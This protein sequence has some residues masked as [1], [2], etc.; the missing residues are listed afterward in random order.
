MRLDSHIRYLDEVVKKVR[1]ST[2]QYTAI[3]L[4]VQY[5]DLPCG[6]YEVDKSH[7]TL[8]SR[9]ICG[10]IQYV[11]HSSGDAS[12]NEIHTSHIGHNAIVHSMT[13][14]THKTVEEIR[15]SIIELIELFFYLALFGETEGTASN[16]LAPDP[17]WL[18]VVMHTI[19]DACSPAHV[20]RKHMLGSEKS[21]VTRKLLEYANN[22][23]RILSMKDVMKRLKEELVFQLE[24]MDKMNPQEIYHYYLIMK[25]QAIYMKQL[26]TIKGVASQ[27]LREDD[28]F[29][30]IDFQNYSKQNGLFHLLRDNEREVN[31]FS[32]E[33]LLKESC[34]FVLQLYMDML[35]TKAMTPSKL[36]EALKT[37]TD[38]LK[39]GVFRIH[40]AFA[41]QI[42]GSH[43][44]ASNKSIR[45]GK[46]QRRGR[47][48]SK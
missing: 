48:A 41:Q 39:A 3:K 29:A 26:N 10:W 43:L 30:I 11:F 36:R 15:D 16:K 25:H 37:L 32:L 35:K 19:M 7:I 6:K 12:F 21:I 34:T 14:Y 2:E 18:G 22:I 27:P 33:P 28:M 47:H 8:K 42:S 4:G 20:I 5:P 1:V 38:T 13:P 31:R 44:E 40:P 46:Q 17:Y 45:G 9:D 24:T 23:P